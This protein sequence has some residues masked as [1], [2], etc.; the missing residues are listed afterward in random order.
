M[1]AKLLHSR[2]SLYDAMDCSPLG[3]SVRGILQQEYWSGLPCLPP[4]SLHDSGI[5][6]KTLPLLHLKH[7]QESSVPF[8]KREKSKL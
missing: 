7:W 2:P 5:E 8:P 6:P 3:S 1:Y 4:G